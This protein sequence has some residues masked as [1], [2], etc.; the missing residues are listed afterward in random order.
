MAARPSSL[1]VSKKA[2]PSSMSI[3]QS[4]G[5]FIIAF[6]CFFNDNILDDHFNE[7]DGSRPKRS[8]ST[9]EWQQKL[10]TASLSRR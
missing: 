3:S 5:C 10:D 7:T 8:I 2:L 9:R 1:R 6:S 4:F